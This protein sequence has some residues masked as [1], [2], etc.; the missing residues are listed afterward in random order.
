M[1]KAIIPASIGNLDVKIETN[2]IACGLPLLLSRESMKATH[3]QINFA[4]DK[5]T[6]L[7]K[8]LNLQFTSRGHYSV[9]KPKQVILQNKDQPEVSVMFTMVSKTTE[10]KRKTAI[11]LHQQFN[12]PHSDGLVKLIKDSG[13]EDGD[14]F[15]MIQE[16]GATCEICIKYKKPHSRP[17]VG[18][19]LGKECN[20]T[21]SVDLKT[22]KGVQFNVYHGFKNA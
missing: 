8:T 2:V 5:V 18:I 12:H 21:V 3:T 4:E 13:I 6:M 15:S 19:S 11:K 20:D 16:V 22:F 1:K 14:L 7:G 9:C 17:A 10:E